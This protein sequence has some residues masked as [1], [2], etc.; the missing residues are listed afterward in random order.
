LDNVVPFR[1]T[2]TVFG[3][4]EELRT[5]QRTRELSEDEIAWLKRERRNW[6][7]WAMDSIFMD[8][9]PQRDL[10]WLTKI[11]PDLFDQCGCGG[12]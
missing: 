6:E 9:W 1:V 3:K 8:E 12:L 2:F 11:A 7:S 4:F 5:A 10:D